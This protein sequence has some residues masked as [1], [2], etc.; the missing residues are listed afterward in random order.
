M[1]C[2]GS[3]KKLIIRVPQGQVLRDVEGRTPVTRS[4]QCKLR[5]P[6]SSR[7]NAAGSNR[8]VFLSVDPTSHHSSGQ[9]IESRR[10]RTEHAETFTQSN[11]YTERFLHTDSST[12]RNMY[13]HAQCFPLSR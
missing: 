2:E 12:H 1:K 3:T 6:N 7:S 5:N 9:V 4:I 10:S 8:N 13:T 11:V